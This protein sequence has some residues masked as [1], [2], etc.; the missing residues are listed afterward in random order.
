MTRL[1]QKTITVGD[2]RQRIELVKLQNQHPDLFDGE[3]MYE[4]RDMD[5]G[6]MLESAGGRQEAERKFRLTIDHIKRGMESTTQRGQPGPGFMS[7]RT[8]LV[9]GRETDTDPGPPTVPDPGGGEP[10]LF[11]MSLPDPGAKDHDGPFEIQSR[12]DS[13]LPDPGAKDHE[14]PFEIKS[15]MDPSMPWND[16]D[17]G[18]DESDGWLL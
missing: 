18:D 8:P 6:T 10:G 12:M 14:G 16:E 11:E 5:T 9:P 3:Y 7:G 17:D 4:I 13:S 15:Q 2:Q 1:K